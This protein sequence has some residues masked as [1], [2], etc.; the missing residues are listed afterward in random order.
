MTKDQKENINTLLSKGTSLEDLFEL[1]NNFL[2]YTSDDSQRRI[3]HGDFTRF[4]QYY[5]DVNNK[6]RFFK[7]PKKSGGERKIFAPDPYLIFIQRTILDILTIYFEPNRDSHGFIKERSIVTNAEIHTNKNYVLNVDIADFFPSIKFSKISALL[8]KAPF[9]FSPEMAKMITRFCVKGGKLPQGAP[10]SP[11]L[12]NIVCQELDLKLKSFAKK[13]KQDYSR[14]ADDI[15]FSGYRRVYD[16][17]FFK[18][19]NKIIRSEKLLLKRSKTRIQPRNKR[20]EVTGLTVND[21]IN[22]NRNYIRELRAMI[23]HYKVGKAP[24]K[25]YAIISGKLEFLKM[26]KGKDRVYKNLYKR[27]KE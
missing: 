23:H 17:D 21:K 7:I 4:Q 26:V 19:L 5:R 13:H 20:Q 8:I 9:N 6:Y 24:D 16:E 1:L 14:Y 15:T 11:I 3:K 27:F 22:V 12:S 10:T 25:A 2:S 18:E